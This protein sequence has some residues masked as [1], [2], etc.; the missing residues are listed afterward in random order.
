MQEVWNLIEADSKSIQE[1]YATQ[2]T[3]EQ[4]FMVLLVQNPTQVKVAN[5][6][7]LHSTD[8]MLSAEWFIQDWKF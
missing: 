3:N 5:G 2:G 4:V 6:G 7:V 8:E 1:N